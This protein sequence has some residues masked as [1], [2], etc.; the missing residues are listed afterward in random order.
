MPR[1]QAD[2]SPVTEADVAGEKALLDAVGQAC[3]GDG[4]LDEEVG[5]KQGTTGRRWIVDGIDGSRSFAAGRPE[6]G[7]LIALEWDSEI[8][9]GVSS[10]PAQEH[11]W[12]AARGAG[13][14][15]G[16]PKDRFSGTRLHVSTE[17]DLN[18]DRFITLPIC[19]DLSVHQRRIVEGLAGGTLRTALGATGTR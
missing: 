9:L 1:R 16:H 19:S 14:F 17:R 4:F 3:P 12:W 13:A 2:G 15:S 6:W 5:E 18:P 10:S 8:V 7:T 11:R